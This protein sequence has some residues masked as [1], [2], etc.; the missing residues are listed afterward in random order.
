VAYVDKA[1]EENEQSIIGIR[2]TAR[3]VLFKQIAGIVA[4]RIVFHLQPGQQVR[5]GDRFGMIRYGS[6]VDIFFSTQAKVKVK[7]G[8]KVSGGTSI[9]GEF[10]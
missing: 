3:Q 6:R 10:R 8:D 9:I 2:G 1:S 4:R 5:A 7:P